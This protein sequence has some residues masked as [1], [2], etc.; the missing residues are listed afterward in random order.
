M[1]DY[2]KVDNMECR[3]GSSKQYKSS[4][5]A[6]T[7]CSRDIRCKNVYDK[8]GQNDFHTCIYS[9]VSKKSD[10]S[11]TFYQKSEWFSA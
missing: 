2:V 7:E 10:C 8:C 1:T 3:A 9:T 4:I 11:S 6:I 5:D